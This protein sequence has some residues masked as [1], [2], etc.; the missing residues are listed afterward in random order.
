M[1]KSAVVWHSS[2]TNKN[3]GDLQRC[4]KSDPEKQLQRNGLKTLR[5]QTIKKRI[6]IVCLKFANNCLKDEKLMNFFPV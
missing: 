5:V 6:E 1:E 3:R 2:L 4:S